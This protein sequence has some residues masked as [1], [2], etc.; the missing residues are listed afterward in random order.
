MRFWADPERF[1]IAERFVKDVEAKR[2][3]GRQANQAHLP[4]L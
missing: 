3:F 4:G 1:A 2:S